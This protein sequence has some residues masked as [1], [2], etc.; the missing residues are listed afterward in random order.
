MKQSRRQMRSVYLTSTDCVHH[1]EKEAFAGGWW[2]SRSGG[3][4]EDEFPLIDKGLIDI[5]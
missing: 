1:V 3:L 2:A 5:R 4:P